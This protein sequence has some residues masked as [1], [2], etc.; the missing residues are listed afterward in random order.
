MDFFFFFLKG[1][2][3]VSNE[4]AKEMVKKI[5]NSD[6][7]K[8][9][10]K[11]LANNKKVKKTVSKAKKTVTKAAKTLGIDVNTIIKYAQKNKTVLDI[12]VKLGLKKES[13]PAS[14]AVQK[15][16]SSLNTAINKAIGFKLEDQS[17]S[18]AVTKLLNVDKIK[19]TLEDEVGKGVNTFIKKAVA[20]YIS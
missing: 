13:D 16:V 1:M 14:S 2:E 6:A 5:T 7:V 9:A 4:D 12:L 8:K 20:E 19:S 11:K 18:N 10:T 15:V 3:L 17:F